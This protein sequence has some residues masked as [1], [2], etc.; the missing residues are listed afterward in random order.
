MHKRSKWRK[1]N[2]SINVGD[3]VLVKDVTKRNQWPIGRI[4][5]AKTSS[6]GLIRSVLIKMNSKGSSPRFLERS[7]RDT[8]LLVSQ[9][10][11]K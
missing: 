4:Y 10:E 8:V 5:S 7:I 11:G 2:T 1:P 9:S 3:V 6:D